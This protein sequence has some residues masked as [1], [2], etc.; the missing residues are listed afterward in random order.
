[1]VFLLGVAVPA[2]A[3]IARLGGGQ[4]RLAFRIVAAVDLLC[5][6]FVAWSST[7]TVTNAFAA[8]PDQSRF[9]FPDGFFD[10]KERFWTLGEVVLH[11]ITLWAP[12]GAALVAVLGLAPRLLLPSWLAEPAPREGPVH[13]PAVAALWVGVCG[14]IGLF[15]AGDGGS[16]PEALFLLWVPVLWLR[17]RGT[18]PVDGLLLVL[19]VATWFQVAEAIVIANPFRQGSIARAPTDAE[20]FARFRGYEAEALVR[21]AAAIALLLPLAGLVAVATRR[22]KAVERVLALLVVVASIT[23]AATSYP[24]PMLHY[25]LLWRVV[26]PPYRRAHPDAGPEEVLIVEPAP[27]P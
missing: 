26:L 23:A 17:R 22:A 11:P 6:A 4:W 25:E 8:G 14:S 13:L 27:G 24:G 19:V 18:D 10:G 15:A 21:M 20:I 16:V 7:R 9:V 2:M 3:M 1:V 5:V 12:L